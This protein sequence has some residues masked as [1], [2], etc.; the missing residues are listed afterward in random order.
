MDRPLRMVT[1]SQVARRFF[2][3]DGGATGARAASN[4]LRKLES[5]HLIHRDIP[6]ARHAAVLR[7]TPAG[8]ELANGNVRP[9]G[10]V[11]AEITHSLAV[12]DLMETLQGEHRGSLL[13]TEREIRV[14][15]GVRSRG[16]TFGDGGRI[17]DGELILKTGKVVAIELDLTPKR[18]VDVKSIVRSYKRTDY[19][20]V[21]WFVRPATV[22]RMDGIVRELGAVTLIEVHP[23]E[24]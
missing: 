1:S 6:S 3:R 16:R 19:A 15:R 13:K 4:R 22:V 17:P 20:A 7:L 5:L 18:S 2:A 9:A 24:G 21:W 23:W 10:W 12:V 11:P 8:A 14:E